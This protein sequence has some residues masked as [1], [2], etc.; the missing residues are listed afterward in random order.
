MIEKVQ[1]EVTTYTTQQLS[2]KNWHRVATHNV[3]VPSKET[4]K[5]E[6]FLSE[7]FSS[8]HEY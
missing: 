5:Y 3:L 6:T 2:K 1:R 7:I 8:F 4:S